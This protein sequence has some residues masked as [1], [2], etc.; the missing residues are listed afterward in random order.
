MREE[1]RL[2]SLSLYVYLSISPLLSS[3]FMMSV[4]SMVV[5]FSRAASIYWY[6][7]PPTFPIILF[8]FI[9]H[10]SISLSPHTHTHTLSHSHK[11]N[12]QEKGLSHVLASVQTNFSKYVLKPQREG[13]GNNLY[14]SQVVEALDHLSREELKAYILME[15][16]H[17]PTQHALL[18]ADTSIPRLAAVTTGARA[19][20]SHK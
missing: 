8:I 20:E 19:R 14:G 13:G 9:I 18:L 6:I 1:A 16:I 11:H 5:F 3:K 12:V 7:F 17:T 10:L 4:L 15:R 2:G